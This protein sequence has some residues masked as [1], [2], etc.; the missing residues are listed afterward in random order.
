[1]TTYN[2]E[3]LIFSIISNNHPSTSAID[4]VVDKIIMRL[5]DY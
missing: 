1:M 4:R 5:L 3:N 2:N